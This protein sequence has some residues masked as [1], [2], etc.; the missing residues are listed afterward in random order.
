MKTTIRIQELIERANKFLAASDDMLVSERSGIYAFVE[1]ILF[2]NNCYNGFN[3]LTKGE[4]KGK[5]TIPGVNHC[6]THDERME[7]MEKT[8]IDSTP[9]DAWFLDCDSSR[10]KLR[11]HHKLIKKV[12]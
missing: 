11:V 8:G 6:C 1:D 3:S 12:K 5:A 4:L 10:K 7:H 2:I 9:I